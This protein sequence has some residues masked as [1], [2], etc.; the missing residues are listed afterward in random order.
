MTIKDSYPMR[1]IYELIDDVASAKF[2]TVLDLKNSC[3]AQQLT[4]DSK[5]YTAF[6]VPGRGQFEYNRSA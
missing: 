3:W 5:A 2:L 4:E 1:N 6:P